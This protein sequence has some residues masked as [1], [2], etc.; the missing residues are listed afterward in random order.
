[1]PY[2]F[3][4]FPSEAWFLVRVGKSD[5]G[6]NGMCLSVGG[7]LSLVEALLS[8]RL[9]T[10]LVPVASVLALTLVL[11]LLVSPFWF[12]PWML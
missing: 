5:C 11:V 1:M 2:H 4:F 8:S 9:L 10:V 7:V 12:V 6:S 3:S